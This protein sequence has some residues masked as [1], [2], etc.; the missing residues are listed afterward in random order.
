MQYLV[1]TY[2]T[3]FHFSPHPQTL[4]QR[5]KY[6]FSYMQI[7]VRFLEILRKNA[8]ALAYVEKKLYL[9]TRF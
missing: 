3:M 2:T 7:L 9:C 1:N 6:F 8:C 5:Y 4:V